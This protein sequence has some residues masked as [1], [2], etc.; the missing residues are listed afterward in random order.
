MSRNVLVFS[1]HEA[2]RSLLQNSL[3]GHGGFQV[4][5]AAEAGDAARFLAQ[6]PVDLLIADLDENADTWQSV[7]AM[8]QSHP[9]VKLVVFVPFND[10]HHPQLSELRPAA[11]LTKPF[12]LPDLLAALEG[13]LA[14]KPPAAALN[15]DP[16]FDPADL[17][18]RL[19]GWLESTRA[20][21]GMILRLGE[22]PLLAGGLA[23]E[24]LR[25]AALVLARSW[26]P[27]RRSDLIRYFRPRSAGRDVLLYATPL[28]ENSQLGVLFEANTSLREARYTTQQIARLC[29]EAPELNTALA[30]QAEQAF[31]T[32]TGLGGEPDL[33][34]ELPLL[35]EEEFTAEAESVRLDDL[36]GSLPPPDA[37]PFTPLTSSEWLPEVEFAPPPENELV[38][39]WEQ[40]ARMQPS[41]A[42]SSPL[43]EPV[44]ASQSVEE[45]RPSRKSGSPP[46]GETIPMEKRQPYT[47][48]LL[49]RSPH[50]T[51]D[52]ELREE[53]QGWIPEFC[54]TLG[55]P[56]ESL[57][58]EPRY[59]LWSVSLPP[60]VSPGYLVR[61]LRDQ[62]SAR[63]TERFANTNWVAAG[64]DFWASAHLIMR[65]RQL[66]ADSL[67]DDFIQRTRRRQGFLSS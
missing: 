54:A 11:C 43:L 17:T 64:G 36:L 10:L 16:P 2:F 8:V 52:G 4:L 60:A 14:G 1:F 58:I 30:P 61:I 35:D 21:G 42:S 3:K 22:P 24:D 46:P 9:K 59:L 29:A 53:L 63:L 40:E 25:E 26:Q 48:I 41:L 33:E 7:R 32:P 49:P 45:T 18:T 62:S 39:P 27:E 55:Y 44:I 20:L 12:Y 28:V 38:L 37:P 50:I 15:D 31:S 13:A 57:R 66:P 34:E 6:Q 5:L 47:C 56:L 23:E 67:I 51:L 65:T 19:A